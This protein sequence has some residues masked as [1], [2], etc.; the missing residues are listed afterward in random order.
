MT[1]DELTI[2]QKAARSDAEAERA[3]KMA[4]ALKHWTGVSDVASANA[5]E[6]ACERLSELRTGANL[7]AIGIR[8]ALRSRTMARRARTVLNATLLRL[9]ASLAVD[10]A[11]K[12][13]V[14]R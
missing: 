12:A 10:D 14:G 13:G 3:R 5:L 4:K 1:R 8:T 9:E 11:E 7:A 2:E 6:E